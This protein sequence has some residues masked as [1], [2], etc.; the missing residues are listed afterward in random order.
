LNAQQSEQDSLLSV[1]KQASGNEKLKVLNDISFRLRFSNPE[2]ALKSGLE[3]ISFRKNLDAGE[4]GIWLD[5]N[6]G[7]LFFDKGK[8]D[9]ALE[10]FIAA[11]KEAERSNDNKNA[12]AAMQNI[13]MVYQ[14]QGF[15]EKALLNYHSALKSF[16][17]IDGKNSIPSVYNSMGALYYELNDIEKALEFFLKSLKISEELKNGKGIADGLNN[18]A[19]IYEEMKNYSKAMEYHKKSLQLNR[20]QSNL[21]AVS[22]SLYN[23]ALI[24]KGQNKYEEAIGYIDSAMITAKEINALD[25]MK[26]YYHTLSEIYYLKN[27]YKTALDYYTKFSELKDTLVNQARNKL[28]VEMSAK[29]QSEKKEKENQILKQQNELQNMSLNRQRIINYSVSVGLFLVLVLA[30]FIYRGYKQKKKANMQL[31]EKNM[32]IEEKNKIVEEKNKDI[33]DSIRYAKRLQTAILKPKETITN[34]FA[35]GFVLFRPKDIVSG[36]FYWFEKF[37]DLSLVAAA[38]CTGHGVPGAFM[39]IIGCNLL[40]Q[41]VNEYA[42]TQPAAILNSINKGLSKVLQQKGDSYAVSDGMDIALCV[43]DPAQMTVEYA[44]AY[45]PMWLVRDDRLK[46][47]KADKFPVGAFVGEQVK[48]FSSLKIPVKKGDMIY[49]F[50]DGYADQFGGP[51]GKKFKYKALQELLLNVH[52]KPCSEQISVIEKEFE[53]WIGKLEQIDD[54]LVIGIRI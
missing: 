9:K 54:V 14:T 47:F 12:G 16:E 41:A 36:D 37:G 49:I 39:S 45:N 8:Y 31:E 19:V 40:S 50:S 11:E 21:R 24:Y 53:S 5:L 7:L 26:E 4:T 28:V 51:Q 23:I 13:G 44:G 1:L 29:Y 43:F 17:E 27:D 22:T 33:T 3:G 46:E 30:F 52:M 15:Y 18:A 42:I 35:D 32:L 2:L 6:V 25:P 20:E 48:Q 34:C 10:H 38:D